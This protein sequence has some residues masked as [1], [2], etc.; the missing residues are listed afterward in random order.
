[1]PVATEL[2]LGDRRRWAER[3]DF[4]PQLPADARGVDGNRQCLLDGAA[5]SRNLPLSPEEVL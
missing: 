1:M 3:R 4:D 5:S 2:Q